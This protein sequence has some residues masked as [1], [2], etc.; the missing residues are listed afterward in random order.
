M[1]KDIHKSP[2]LKIN[3]ALAQSVLLLSTLI[4]VNLVDILSHNFL[5][6]DRILQKYFPGWW[7]GLKLPLQIDLDSGKSFQK[8]KF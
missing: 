8:Q 7:S 4:E 2:T 5:L 6:P 1:S 3:A